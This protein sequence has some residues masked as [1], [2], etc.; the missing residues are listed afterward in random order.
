M[1]MCEDS[2]SEAGRKPDSED[3]KVNGMFSFIALAALAIA[4][5]GESEVASYVLIGTVVVWFPYYVFA[6]YMDREETDWRPRR[7]AMVIR[8]VYNV[9]FRVAKYSALLL[10]L[11]AISSWISGIYVNP[12]TVIIVLLIVIIWQL[13]QLQNERNNREAR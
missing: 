7:A 12:T 9:I 2:D 4:Y 10:L 1:W 13:R 5:L 8:S 11:L 3:V 6:S